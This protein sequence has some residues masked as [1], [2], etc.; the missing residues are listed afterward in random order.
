MKNEKKILIL[1]FVVLLIILAS[2]K[3]EKNNFGPLGSTHIHADFKVYI[4][5]S[6]IDFSLQKY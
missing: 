5:G 3:N 1:G 6:P 2:C 4:L